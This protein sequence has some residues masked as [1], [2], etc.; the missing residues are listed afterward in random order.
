MA[1]SILPENALSIIRGSSK[2]LELSVVD[3]SDAAVPLT[4]AQIYFT[5]KRC[6]DDSQSLIS[7][8]TA[9]ITQI[10]IT[11]AVGGKARIF[12]NPGD[13][14]N[15]PAGNYTFD[16][17]VV[18]TSGKRFPVVL[19]STFEVLPGVTVIPL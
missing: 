16:V 14:Q 6:A 3:D 4:G 5:V 7:K 8:T 11:S 15:M 17:W 2:T 18:L 19:P 10:E 13:T 1:S 12:L 9:V